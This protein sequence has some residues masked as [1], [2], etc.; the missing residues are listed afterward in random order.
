MFVKKQK[1]VDINNVTVLGIN[2]ATDVFELH[3]VN[4]HGKK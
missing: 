4:V 1:R 2:L 3:G